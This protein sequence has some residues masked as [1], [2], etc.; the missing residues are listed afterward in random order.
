MCQFEEHPGTTQGEAPRACRQA[1]KT[2]PEAKRRHDCGVAAA[3]EEALDIN[4]HVGGTHTRTESMLIKAFSPSPNLAQSGGGRG[5]LG[6]G[7]VMY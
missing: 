6:G 1:L 2:H 4:V 5:W 3:L 7:G